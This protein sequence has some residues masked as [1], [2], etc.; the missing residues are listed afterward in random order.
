MS[1]VYFKPSVEF[2]DKANKIFEEQKLR[3]STLLPYANVEH[4]GSTAIP[5]SVTKGDIDISI[6]VYK[7]HFIEAVKTLKTIYEVNQTENW[8]GTFASFKDES[9]LGIDFGVQLVVKDSKSDDF[10][11][12]RDIL[13]ENPDLVKEYN[14]MKLKH[15]GKDMGKYRK[16]KADFFQ[17]LR[18]KYLATQLAKIPKKA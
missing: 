4:I 13:K 17:K 9:S 18:E 5:N 7:D 6:K 3:I 8:T 16:E 14:A 11:K 15:E 1:Q 2:F 12:L 10:T